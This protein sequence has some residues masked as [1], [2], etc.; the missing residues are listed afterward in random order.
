MIFR[1]GYLFT[2]SHTLA[3]P[4][5]GWLLLGLLVSGLTGHVGV[6]AAEAPPTLTV[7]SSSVELPL[8]T[9]LP[10]GTVVDPQTGW[11]LVEQGTDVAIP[12]QIG[13][14]PQADGEV[15]EGRQRVLAVI[16]PG[17][18]GDAL[19]SFQLL[20]TDEPAAPVFAFEDITDASVKARQ[21]DQP[22]F[23]YN[24]GVITREDLPASERRRSRACYIHPVYGM[25]GEVL[26]DDFP[27]DHYHHHG[28]FWTWPFIGVNGQR[29]D[30][31]HDSALRQ[32]FSRWL[33]RE[34][35][36]VAAVLAVENGWIVD[37]ERL[38]IERVWMR[39]F[40]AGQ[41]DRAL[42]VELFFTP[43]TEITLRGAAGKSYGGL[44]VRFAPG[45]RGETRITVPDG[46]TTG[47]L[48]D[49]PLKWADF[50]SRFGEMEHRS[51][52][53]VLVPPHHP[54][55]PPSWLTR[56]YGPLCIGWPGVQARTFEPG[57]PFAIDYR[58]WIHRE[59]GD[60][61]ELKD[62][63]QG[64]TRATQAQWQ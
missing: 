60:F 57:T 48:P 51:G 15:A 61:E 30:T 39:A 11:H 22:V 2:A 55:Y 46:P 34:V 35:G 25:S 16:P 31:W 63:Y 52:A 47:D 26:T 42:D 6:Q 29:Y 56:H 13:S 20:P 1:N 58:M 64:Y 36:P 18:E 38:M 53:A 33:V 23:V 40:R 12:A 10:E 17:G 43:E 9:I 41:D 8:A 54:D 24:H 49:T 28:V 50:T 19:R 7:M 14:A 45:S 3:R 4:P 27:R 21:G 37:D 44:T 59:A 32:V 5:I 62:V